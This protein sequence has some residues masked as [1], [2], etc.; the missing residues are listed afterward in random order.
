M[1]TKNWIDVP[2]L[3]GFNVTSKCNL[4]CAYCFQN[5]SKH[6][7]E[8]ASLDEIL[9]VLS[10]IDNIGVKEILLEGGEILALPFLK[11]L[12]QNLSIYN[13]KIHII[14]NG[15]LLTKEIADTLSLLNI[16]VGVS[17]DGPE[18][19]YNTF[20]S[21]FAYDKAITAIKLLVEREIKTYVNCTITRINADKIEQLANLCD[22]LKCSGLVLQQLHC[23]GNSSISFYNDNYLNLNQLCALKKL[24]PILRKKYINL[25]FVES[26][27]L[28]FINVPGRYRKVCKPEI[29]YLPKKIFRCAAGRRFCLIKSN[30][31]VIPCGILEN[32]PCGNLRLK[33]FSE[34]WKNSP[35][36]SFIREISESRVDSIPVCSS[37][38][39][40]PIC[41]GG[42]RGD[43]YNYTNDW[44]S[45]HMFCPFKQEDTIDKILVN[46]ING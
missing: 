39:Y 2:E 40:N 30:L 13:F 14:T 44:Y 27:V 9:M 41:D 17:L 15:I 4:K 11:S 5:N 22:E 8:D 45:T 3:V 25:E 20:R 31:D 34:I 29:D 1:T 42:C 43:V 24:I 23:S 46:T 36:L 38:I 16:S 10:Q 33:S 28:D 19:G 37:C 21:T 18:P 35:E 12:L 26:E 6:N 32:Y 7:I